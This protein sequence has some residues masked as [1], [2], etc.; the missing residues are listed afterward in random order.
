MALIS[1]DCTVVEPEGMEAQMEIKKVVFTEDQQILCWSSTEFYI[2]DIDGSLVHRERV[3]P[4]IAK[5]VSKQKHFKPSK[6]QSLSIWLSISW[7][8]LFSEFARSLLQRQKVGKNC[9]VERR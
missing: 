6:S 4:N 3:D 1:G 7:P 5:K 8:A 2:Y 9:F